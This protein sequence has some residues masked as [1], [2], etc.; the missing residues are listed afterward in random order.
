M[1]RLDIAFYAEGPEPIARTSCAG[2]DDARR[3]IEKA[4]KEH[5][6]GIY[7]A[8]TWGSGPGPEDRFTCYYLNS[9]GEVFTSSN[10]LILS[11]A[12]AFNLRRRP[13]GPEPLTVE[14]TAKDRRRPGGLGRRA[15][16]RRHKGDRRK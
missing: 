8:T 6:K 16:E 13:T 4:L 7:T 15:G 3:C 2:M 14:L 1:S 5:A 10:P 12:Q 9:L 11:R